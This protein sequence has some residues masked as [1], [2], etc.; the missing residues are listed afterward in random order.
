MWLL[1]WLV[2]K[3]NRAMPTTFNIG[4]CQAPKREATSV[5]DCS[6]SPALYSQGQ[7]L[8]G[9]SSGAQ[10]QNNYGDCYRLNRVPLKIHVENLTP[11]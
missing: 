1:C 9:E 4:Q 5:L 8:A 10:V 2:A 7:P 6:H 11:R 3:P